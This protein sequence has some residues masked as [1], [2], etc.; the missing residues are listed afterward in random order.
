MGAALPEPVEPQTP[1]RSRIGMRIGIG[2]GVCLAIY[3]GLVFAVGREIPVGTT[4]NGVEIGR[5]TKA[6]ATAALKDYAKTFAASQISLTAHGEITQD[7]ADNLG[8]NLDV[9]ATIDSINTSIY[10]P[11]EIL[12][13]FFG[14]Q[15]V[16]PVIV[17]DGALDGAISDIAASVDQPAVDAGIKFKSGIAKTTPSKVGLILD[18]ESSRDLIIETVTNNAFDV[19]TPL[20]L[21]MVEQTPDVSNEEAEA[22]IVNEL[23]PALSAPVTVTAQTGS[24]QPDTSTTFSVED[25]EAAVRF[26]KV[27]GELTVTLNAD[28]INKRTDPEFVAVEVPVQE[29]TWD[30]SSGTPVV[31]PS[32]AGFG[33][34]DLSMIE[35]I[36]SV[37]LL[38]EGQRTTQV[39]FGAIQPTFTT[40][41]AE[42]MGVVELVSSYRQ[43]F[44]AAAYRSINIGRAAAYMNGTLI[45]PGEV[46]SM[47]KTILERTYE[48][49]YTDGWIIA[50]G[51][52]FKMEAGGGV[53]TATTATFNAA[54][55]AG[56]EFLEWRAHSVWIP[57]RYVPG[58]EA[59]VFWGA[60]DMRWRN[61]HP[62]GIF[63]TTKMTKTSITVQFWGTKQYDSIGT[64]FGPKRNIS[65][66]INI[67][68][69]DPACHAQ[70][71]VIGFRI[72][73][74]R[75][76]YKDA[77]EV[78]REP[79]NT[80]YRASPN[81]ICTA[82]SNPK[83]KPTKTKT[84][85]ATATATNTATA[86]ATPT[87]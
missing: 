74:Y 17:A 15:E 65:K 37:W 7:T 59:T 53:S 16:T 34:T 58:R 83:P 44:P 20:E 84:P 69:S 56:V 14:G 27:D 81:V 60:L 46:Y 1:S 12:S 77:A 28:E 6:D 50:G 31:V 71:G 32:K 38:P 23:T 22:L 26:R 48:N 86:T 85:T 64:E 11:I 21:P 72:T 35:S 43:A 19:E 18:Q 13:A 63:I 10:N 3:G 49:G 36:K 33:I 70:N 29:A 25:L 9:E 24:A 51:G 52:I 39:V 76:F 68:N 8:L 61:N 78:K 67:E 4:V 47:N 82:G 5:M 40:E 2:L 57:D 66:P 87:P 55:F 62:T 75:T 41:E 42:K 79:F 30:V 80:S 54:W 73:T 45:K